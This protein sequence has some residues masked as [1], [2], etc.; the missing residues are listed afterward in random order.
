MPMPIANQTPI[1]ID[2]SSSS[3]QSST[4]QITFTRSQVLTESSLNIKQ[5]QFVWAFS[6]SKPSGETYDST[7]YKHD[8]SGPFTLDLT[9][10]LGDSSS[11]SSTSGGFAQGKIGL[12]SFDQMVIAHGK[13]K[14]SCIF[15]ICDILAE[16]NQALIP[17]FNSCPHVRGL[18]HFDSVSVSTTDFFLAVSKFKFNF[19]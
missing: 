2:T 4:V 6:S 15:Y 12:S 1:A 16:P 7:I 5:T 17:Y 11:S 3:V 9:K 14:S 10:S 13:L 19:G 8:A 18:V